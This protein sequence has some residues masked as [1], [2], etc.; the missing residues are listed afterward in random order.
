MQRVK[1]GSYAGKNHGRITEITQSQISLME[2][3]PDGRD[4]WVERPR[5]IVMADK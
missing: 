2:I 5:S 3:V 4:G 1:V